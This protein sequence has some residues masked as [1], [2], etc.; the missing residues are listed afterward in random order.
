MPEKTDIVVIGAGNAALSAAISAAE[1]GAQVTVLEISSQEEKGGNTAYTHGSIRFSY[2]NGEQVRALL[3]DMTDEEFAMVDFG[4]YTKE[5]FFDDLCVMS[6]YRT[7]YDLASIMTKKS[8]ETVQWLSKHH[9]KWIPIYG[10]QAYKIDDKFVFW[11]GMVI[12]AVGGGKGLVEALHR[13]AQKMGISILYNTAA[14]DLV[15]KNRT[16]EGVIVRSNG[17]ERV[18]ACNAVV[19]ASGGFHANV[20]MRTKYLGPGWDTVHTRGCKYSVGDGLRMAMSLG[21]RTTGNWSGAHAVSG[22]RHLPD[23]KEGFQKLS[24]PFGIMVNQKGQRFIDEGANFR[25]Y[26]YAKV[27]REIL[28]QPGQCA[29]QVYDAKVKRFIR[30][31]YNGR[32]VSKV[33]ANTLEELAKKM[34]GMDAQ[35]FLQEVGEYNASVSEDIAFNPNRLDG[36]KTNGLSVSKSN[37]ANRLDEGPFEAYE[38]GCGI[39]FT[40]GGLKINKNAQ[41]IHNDFTPIDGLYAAGEIVGGLY[42]DNYPGGAG[43]TSGAVFG[44]LAGEHASQFVQTKKHST[45]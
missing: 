16:I 30:E 27:G 28:K 9:V 36:K 10:R 23:Y 1:N 24:F 20:E 13:E 2:K 7:D 21:A 14:I 15:T 3:P 35:A 32:Q 43:L 22:D 39:T 18:I 40:Y 11:G 38:V 8:F 42:Y 29:W 26:I 12:E 6:N 33:T 34:E 5:Q 19:L 4:S 44:K 17:E 41:V 25:N 37:W 45:V 31:E